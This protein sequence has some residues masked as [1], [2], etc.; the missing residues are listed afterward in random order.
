MSADENMTPSERITEHFRSGAAGPPLPKWNPDPDPMLHFARILESMGE[1]GWCPETDDLDTLADAQQEN[2][3]GWIAE[4]PDDPEMPA[5]AAEW[6]EQELIVGHHDPAGRLS[7]A[8]TTG[9]VRGDRKSREVFLVVAAFIRSHRKWPN[10]GEILVP[11]ISQKTRDNAFQEIEEK[12]GV[13]IDG[14]ERWTEP[15]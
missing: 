2:L 11:D 5:R 4:N 9:K 10:R 3:L 6:L 7:R 13:R 15:Q 1:V 8:M 14:R 12:F